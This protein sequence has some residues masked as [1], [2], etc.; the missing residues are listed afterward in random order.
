[1]VSNVTAV[2]HETIEI[3]EEEY[4][5]LLALLSRSIDTTCR[6]QAD[7][8]PLTPPVAMKLMKNLLLRTTLRNKVTKIR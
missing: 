3:G 6:N 2:D 8:E 7:E 4:Y 1:V 5:L